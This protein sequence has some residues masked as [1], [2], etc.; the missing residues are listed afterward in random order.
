MPDQPAGADSQ[1]MGNSIRGIIRPLQFLLQCRKR[2]VAKTGMDM[3]VYQDILVI[4]GCHIFFFIRKMLHRMVLEELD[5]LL[6]C[7]LAFFV[8][9]TE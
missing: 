6:A 7:P 3:L 1:K 8:L 2:I 4:N 9:L 5:P